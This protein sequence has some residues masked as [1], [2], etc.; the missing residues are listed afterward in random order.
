LKKAAAELPAELVPVADQLTPYCPPMRALTLALVALCALAGCGGGG[1][2][3]HPSAKAAQACLK[4]AG[5][6]VQAIQSKATGT[7]SARTELIVRL[8]D[9]GTLVG[10]FESDKAA[11]N[12]SAVKK[13]QESGGD[14]TVKGSTALVIVP[15]SGQGGRPKIE[16]CV[17]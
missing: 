10:F 5:A 7:D 17:F 16:E 3:K 8:K 13:I 14:V 4:K 2:E 15:G 6:T 11:N 1:G 12:P 9:T